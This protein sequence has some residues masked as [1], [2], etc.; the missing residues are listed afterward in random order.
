MAKYGF[1][2][3]IPYGSEMYEVTGEEYCEWEDALEKVGGSGPASE[4]ATFDVL[5]NNGYFVEK[6]K[7]ER[8]AVGNPEV[9]AGTS[10]KPGK[11]KKDASAAV[12]S[13]ESREPVWTQSRILAERDKLLTQREKITTLKEKALSTKISSQQFDEQIRLVE[14]TGGE[15][16]NTFAVLGGGVILFG[17]VMLLVILMAG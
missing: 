7:S 9:L 15:W 1:S 2:T 3:T 6:P 14:K 10:R 11:A 5:I 17:F 12:I 13:G 16:D 4:W 8:P